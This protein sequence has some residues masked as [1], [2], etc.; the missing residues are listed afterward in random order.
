MRICF[1][2]DYFLKDTSATITGP[3]V[4]TYLLASGLARRGWAVEFV[5]TTHSSRAG[6]TETHNGISVH[7]V[8]AA[9]KLEIG[10]AL[11][12]R[13]RLASIRADVFYQ[14]GRSPLTGITAQAARR[15][16]GKFIWASSD[17]KSVV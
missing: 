6:R 1:V 14:R 8:K 3:M 10:S 17:R 15:C 16:G 13:K 2:N 12:V 7:Y 4:Q 11:A 9:E 5:A